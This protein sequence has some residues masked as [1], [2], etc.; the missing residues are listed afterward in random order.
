[1]VGK[2]FQNILVEN[3]NIFIKA[4]EWNVNSWILFYTLWIDIYL[5]KCQ[6]IFLCASRSEFSIWF[7]YLFTAAFQ[8]VRNNLSELEETAN[9]TDLAFLKGLLDNP[10]VSEAI[11]VSCH[12][13]QLRGKNVTDLVTVYACLWSWNIFFCQFLNNFS[14]IFI[15]NIFTSMYEGVSKKNCKS[16]YAHRTSW[17]SVRF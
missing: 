10:A 4:C 15:K 5:S 17:T 16:I 12:Y 1:M 2:T 14:F 3:Q 11:K 7:F 9:D 8:H 13:A 6:K